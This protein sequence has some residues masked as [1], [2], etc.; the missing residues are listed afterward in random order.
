MFFCL[1][2]ENALCAGLAQ[3]VGGARTNNTA[4]GARINNTAV[5]HKNSNSY[6]ASVWVSTK[7]RLRSYLAL[8]CKFLLIS[9]NSQNW[10][11]REQY[12]KKKRNN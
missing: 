5:K 8:M 1:G 6:K 9:T 2:E 3:G 12:S 11:I 7:H 4:G 10:V